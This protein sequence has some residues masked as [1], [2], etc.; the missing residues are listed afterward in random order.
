MRKELIVVKYLRSICKLNSFCH[1]KQINLFGKKRYRPDIIYKLHDRTIIVEIDEYQHAKY[2]KL[3]EI[4]RS[5]NIRNYYT[6]RPF[7]MVRFN[8]DKYKYHGKYKNPCLTK[9]LNV[10]RKHIEKIMNH[11]SLS[12]NCCHVTEL[13]YDYPKSHKHIINI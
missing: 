4:I 1:N 2:N 6:D 12:E 9:R 7:Y 11:K 5:N 13:Y 8:T 3:S 10:L